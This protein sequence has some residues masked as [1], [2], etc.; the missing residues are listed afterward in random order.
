MLKHQPWTLGSTAPALC[1]K[2]N[3][4]S[5]YR[6]HTHTTLE[7]KR[8][9]YGLKRPFRCHD[10]GW[11]GWIEESQ[12]RYSAEVI[13]YQSKDTISKDLAIPDILLDTDSSNGTGI[14]EEAAEKSPNHSGLEQL[15]SFDEESRHAVSHKV[16][17]DFHHHSRHTIKTCPKCRE[18]SLYRSRSRSLGETIK[19]KLTIKRP[20]RCHRCGWRGWL[21][22]GF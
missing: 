14:V 22:R 4:A 12:L 17:V 20:Y 18:A 15:P 21:S 6:S 3:V 8:K 2:C 11:R 16:P 13:S 10:C 5:L 7:E 19:K 9:H 1:P